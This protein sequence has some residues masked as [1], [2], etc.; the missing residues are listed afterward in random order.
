MIWVSPSN[1]ARRANNSAAG[2]NRLPA[3]GVLLLAIC[4]WIGL[5]WIE[6]Q[7]GY[8]G[9][10]TRTV[11]LLVATGLTVCALLLLLKPQSVLQQAE[12]ATDGRKPEYGR[13]V[14]LIAG[15]LL[16]ML[17]IGSIGFPLASVILMVCVA[18]G[19]RSKRPLRDAIVSLC[20][21]LPLWF[22]FTKL[23]AI[24]LPLLPLVGL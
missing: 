4:F 22:I 17:L 1:P 24:N 7:S 9:I 5:F 23:L 13:L 12:E 8:A 10:S 6:S 3:L 15:L 2:V 11:P 20:I 14:W 21:T 19:Y 16:T 18:R